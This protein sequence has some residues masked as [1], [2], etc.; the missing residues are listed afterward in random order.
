MTQEPTAA[1]TISRVESRLGNLQKDALLNRQRDR[2]GEIDAQL[3]RLPQQVTQLRARGYLYKAHL[4]QQIEQ[5]AQRWPPIR[6]Q[7]AMALDGQAALLRPEIER[8]DEAV[9]RLQPLKT[10]PLS[11]AQPTIQRVEDEL[12]ATERRIRAAQQAVEG[13][14]GALANEVQ[15]IAREVQSCERMLDWLAGAT[16]AADPGEGLVAATE[17]RW[18]EGKDRTEGILFLTD[19]RLV[20]ERREKVALKKFLF[21]TTSSELVRELRWQAAL[22]DLERL[23]ASE[24]RKALVSKRELLTVQPRSGARVRRGEFELSTDSDAWRALVL[25]CQTGE[26]A[27]ERAGGAP[28]VP[29]YVV[30]AKCTSCGGSLAQ[31]GR[32]R[33]VS[34]VR[35][36]YCGANIPL[37]RA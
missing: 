8:A 2:L 5:V 30:P 22:A 34:V 36:D 17:A 37:E 14:F 13:A 4:E 7:A 6:G 25:R 21:V 28:Q 29:E 16:F 11:T 12:S 3:A 1:S 15:A 19:R 20:F 10:R 26:I 23:E 9:R 24:A 31:A 33:G 27:S 35:C 18:V 32:I